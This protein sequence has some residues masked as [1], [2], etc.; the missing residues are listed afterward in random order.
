[1]KNSVKIERM[2]NIL[3]SIKDILKDAKFVIVS[4]KE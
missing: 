2:E 4:L 1:M 3:N